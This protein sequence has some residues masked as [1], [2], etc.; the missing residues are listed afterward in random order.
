MALTVCNHQ[1]Y[2]TDSVLCLYMPGLLHNIMKI[3]LALFR[4]FACYHFGG[5]I[6]VYI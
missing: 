1:K 3:P 5:A 2:A 4:R 6:G